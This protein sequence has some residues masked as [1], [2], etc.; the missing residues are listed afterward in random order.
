LR[1][2]TLGKEIALPNGLKFSDCFKRYSKE[3]DGGGR[4]GGGG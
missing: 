3:E 2:D 1:P 4:R